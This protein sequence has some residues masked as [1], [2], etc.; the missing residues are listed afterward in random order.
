MSTRPQLR[1]IYRLLARVQRRERMAEAIELTVRYSLPAGLIL[2]AG[3]VI[4][5]RAF[6]TP[7]DWAWVASAP[8]PVVLG[9]A[10]LR[11]RSLRATARRV[12]AHYRLHD[13]L[14]NA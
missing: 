12:D 3:A 9:W 14:G 6:L 2:A 10:A 5:S 1:P 4:S 7:M 11:R 13:R 8:I